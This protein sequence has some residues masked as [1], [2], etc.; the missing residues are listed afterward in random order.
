MGHPPHM[1]PLLWDLGHEIERISEIAGDEYMP[2]TEHTSLTVYNVLQCRTLY[3]VIENM[4]KSVEMQ[5]DLLD[6][7]SGISFLGS[8]YF[9]NWQEDI[10]HCRVERKLPSL[11]PLQ[12]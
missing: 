12:K 3:I 6:R 1:E 9:R 8:W 5:D 2:Q 10:N 11:N 7:I 4:L